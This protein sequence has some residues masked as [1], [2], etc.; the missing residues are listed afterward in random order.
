[1]SQMTLIWYSWRPPPLIIPPPTSTVEPPAARLCPAKPRPA[2]TA[3]GGPA[4]RLP[5][6]QSHTVRTRDRWGMGT[7]CLTN[8]SF[9]RL[10]WLLDWLVAVQWVA[11]PAWVCS[12]IIESFTARD[13]RQVLSMLSKGLQSRSAG[14]APESSGHAF[15]AQHRKKMLQ[16]HGEWL[17]DAQRLS[18]EG[19]IPR[20]H[21]VH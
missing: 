7:T 16:N 21:A 8:R 5:C 9:R 4:G 10:E 11:L 2:A 6:N 20:G 12:R 13:H 19:L 15:A 3:A 14:K 1:M 18:G 17:A